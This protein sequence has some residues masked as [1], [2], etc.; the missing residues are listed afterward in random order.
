MAELKVVIND[1]K[2]GKSYQKVLPENPFI[3][4]KV[5]DSVKGDE[6][7]LSGYEFQITGGSDKSGCP[8]RFDMPGV[9]KKTALLSSGPCVNINVKG[10]RVRKTVVGNTVNS[11]IVQL[12]MKVVN[13]GSRPLEEIFPKKEEAKAA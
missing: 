2:T 8:I 6:L 11:D 1:T 10:K 7:E 5:K 13:Y 4:K 9:G 3:N 12:N